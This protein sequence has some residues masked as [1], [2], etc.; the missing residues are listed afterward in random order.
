MKRNVAVVLAAVLAVAAAIFVPEVAT[1][2]PNPAAF[3]HRVCGAPAPGRA[4]CHAHVVDLDAGSAT[5]PPT[6]KATASP[7]GLTPSDIRTAYG[8]TASATAGAGKT[9]AIVDAYDS[10]TAE[11]DLNVF[12]STFGLPAC[13]TANLCFKKVNQTGGS[14]Y[15]QVNAGWA[16]EIALDVQ[17]AHAVAPGAKILLVEASSNSFTNL[18]AAVD[19]ARANADYISMSWGA[20]EFSGETIYDSHF[21][22][23]KS[24]FVSAGD[25]GTPAEYPSSSPKVLSIGGTR[26]TFDASHDLVS[27]TGWTGGGGGCSLYENKV[28]AQTT[29]SV[30]CNGKRATPDI[31]LDADPASGVSVYDTTPYNGATG[32]F[33]VGGTSASAPMIAGR[34]AVAGV[35]VDAAFVYGAGPTVRDITVGNNGA[36]CLTGFDLCSGRGSWADNGAIGTTTTTSSTS[37]TT[38]TSTTST[39]TSSTSTTSTTAPPTAT[40]FT[41]TSPSGSTGYAVTPNKKG[42][43]V[44]VTLRNNLSQAVGGASV[45][46]RMTKGGVAFASGSGTTGTTG[47]ATFRVNTASSGTYSTTV[48]AVTGTSLTWLGGTPVNSFTK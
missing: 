1:G 47:S 42:F 33:T 39:T 17:W 8:Y 36:P 22:A 10:P 34:S 11:N 40:S 29:G 14:S 19:Y 27:E 4:S 5:R 13:T 41:V 24:Y 32:W 18:M 9:I 15:P 38:T 25:N 26:L 16:L 31:S 30:S 28:A 21:A 7:T 44:T 20:P 48:T 6:P 35:L 45:S 3:E 2:A 43:T 46:I 12:S 37:S 23:G